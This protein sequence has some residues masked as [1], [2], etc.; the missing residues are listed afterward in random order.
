M[1]CVNDGG[2]DGRMGGCT[3][4]LMATCRGVGG[5][6]RGEG[7]GRRGVNGASNDQTKALDVVDV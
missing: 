5:G 7:G 3:Y 6:G 4:R 1:G 2:M